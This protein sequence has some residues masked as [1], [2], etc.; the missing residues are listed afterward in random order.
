MKKLVD[1]FGRKKP[2]FMGVVI[3]IIIIVGSVAGTWFWKNGNNRGRAGRDMPQMPGM[4]EDVIVASGLR[5]TGMNEEK[6]ELDFLETALYVEESYLS[7]GDTVEAGEAVFK[8]SED[9]LAKAREELENTKTKANLEY[10]QGV[11]NYETQK[12]EAEST[13][14]QAKVNKDYAQAEYDSALQQA[15]QEVDTLT[16]QVAEA[17]ELYD[18]YKAVVENNYYYTY[19][20]VEE[21]KQIYYE[22]F[23]YLMELYEKWNIDE[24]EDQYPNVSSS[25]S[26]VGTTGSTGTTSSSG[27]SANGG[28]KGGMSGGGSFYDENSGKLSVYQMMDELVQKNGDEY[29]T[30]LENYE[31]DTKTATASLESARSQLAQLQADLSDAQLEYEKQ[32]ITEKANYDTTI[33]ESEN[34]EAVYDTEMKKLEEELE[35]LKDEK[36]EAEENLA[37][38]EDTI[39]DGYFYTASAGTVVMNMVRAG[40]YLFGDS[41][42]LAYSDSN[43]VTVE[44][45]VEQDDIAKIAVGDGAYV[46]IN[47][48]GN[49]EGTVISIN[50]VSS[51]DSR[52]SVTYTVTVE[53]TGDIEGLE[54]NLTAYVYFGM[55]E[56]EMK[57]N[58]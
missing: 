34:A 1:K 29:E 54:S 9:T 45:S 39:G 50:P 15:K 19:Y 53:L 30:A 58:E 5:A 17:Q 35:V 55:S 8:V 43:T 26:S 57:Q 40:N 42:V 51:S 46:M 25:F 48:Y 44:A 24:L 52:S 18:E 20:R 38:F 10:R 14:A 12:L 28:M 47:E 11:I 49:Y 33:A 31:K 32:V 27:A 37:L 23:T 2:V 56:E 7:I 4:S 6:Y 13:F 16:K 21:L 36:N 22:N 41:M 3:V